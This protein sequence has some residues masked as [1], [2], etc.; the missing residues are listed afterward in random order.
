MSISS[1]RILL[2]T[3]SIGAEAKRL[4][5]LAEFDYEVLVTKHLF[6]SSQSQIDQELLA[7]FDVL[8]F[9]EHLME[10]TAWRIA[11]Q[12]EQIKHIPKILLT[13]QNLTPEFRSICVSCQ[14]DDC[15]A[16]NSLTVELVSALELVF[17]KH[18]AI[19]LKM[20]ALLNDE[21][22]DPVEQL[23]CQPI[24]L[25]KLESRI[26]TVLKEQINQPISVED[27][28]EKIWQKQYSQEKKGLVSFNVRNLRKRLGDNLKNPELIVN[29]RGKGY[30]M[31][32][33]CSKKEILS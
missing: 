9:S 26:Y 28:Y 1:I 27:L 33:E 17:Q 6:D 29:I 22:I 5:E 18:H 14:V 3:Q 20:E 7:P 30:M 11:A 32:M 25:S 19:Q 31:T 23:E 16:A 21:P 24:L 13:H 8:L 4:K 15:L 12:V 10:E 2:V